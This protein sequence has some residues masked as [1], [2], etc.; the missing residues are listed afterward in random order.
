VTL[1][2]HL[3]RTAA[4]GVLTVGSA[5]ALTVA[6]LPPADASPSSQ[7]TPTAQANGIVYA[8]VQVGDRTF[9][10]GL[11]TEVGGLPRRNVAAILANGEVDPTWNPSPNGV[12]YSLA[13][14]SDGSTVFVGGNFTSI[15]GGSRNRL[16]AVTTATGANVTNW[17]A[18]ATRAVRA[19][20]VEGDR[21][22]VGGGFDKIDGLA[23]PRL[24]AVQASTGVTDAGFVPAPDARI[25]GLA[26]SGHHLYAGGA[27]RAIG[28]VTRPGI[29]ELDAATGAVTA[30]EPEDG[31]VVLAVDLTP[32]GSRLFFSTTSNRTWA[33]DPAVSDTGVYRVRTGGDVQAIEA[34]A[35][36]VYVGGHFNGLPEFKLTRPRLASFT[37]DGVPTT[38]RVDLD[39]FW[40]VWTISAA[41]DHLNV[42][43]EFTTVN[44]TTQA[45]YARFAGKP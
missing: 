14:A 43:G 25:S 45:G 37:V 38:W 15:A 22:Y 20:A 8:S 3:S 12:V 13:A 42:G 17:R 41:A 40:G 5:L 39:S 31:G 11:F 27:Y 19:M 26:V 35:T 36:E 7:L 44:G 2:S 4:I 30:F 1:R 29:S 33:Y 18:N 28:G 34:T 6:A 32:D 9:I 23:I 16:A 24:A 10:G 21:L